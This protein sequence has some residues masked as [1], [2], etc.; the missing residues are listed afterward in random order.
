MEPE[1]ALPHSQVP[2][3]VPNL[4]H[5]GPVHA[6]KSH[7]QKI[8]FNIILPSTPGSSMWSLS[9]RFPHQHLVYTSTLHHI[10]YIPRTPHSSRFHMSSY[11]RTTF[12]PYPFL[13]FTNQRLTWHD[14]FRAK[15]SIA[16]NKNST[17]LNNDNEDEV[18]K[19]HFTLQQAMKSQRGNR[20]TAIHFLQPRPQMGYAIKA[21]L[22]PLYP[23]E[24]N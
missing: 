11:A 4:S 10:R 19:V 12:L 15:G 3:T 2:P 6:L 20:V 18:K 1:N 7:F 16:K 17:F 21:T 5:I 24:K 14:E 8:H 22:R 13:F 23:R 9:L